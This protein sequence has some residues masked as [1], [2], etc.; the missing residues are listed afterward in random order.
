MGP[1]RITKKDAAKAETVRKRKEREAFDEKLINAVRAY[2]CLYNKQT[3][4][5]SDKPKTVRAWTQISLDLGV[6]DIDALKKAWKYLRTKYFKLKKDGHVGGKS[7]D[8]GAENDDDEDSWVLTPLLSFLNGFTED[9][10]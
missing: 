1:K 5:Y 9:K 10:A 8:G 3:K 4:D 7:G 2:P 6:D